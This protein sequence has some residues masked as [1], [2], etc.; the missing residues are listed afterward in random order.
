[1]T[2][3]PPSE[4]VAALTLNELSPVLDGE[5]LPLRITDYDWYLVHWIVEALKR[6]EAKKPK[7]LRVRQTKTLLVKKEFRDILIGLF[8][9]HLKVINE[10]RAEG[11]LALIEHPQ[12]KLKK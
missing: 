5:G 12:A 8:F 9:K 1:M 6:E 11:K 4:E 7:R 3:K 10:I 2:E